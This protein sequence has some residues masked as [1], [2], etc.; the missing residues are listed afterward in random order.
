MTDFIDAQTGEVLPNTEDNIIVAFALYM[1]EASK[2]PHWVK[3]HHLTKPWKASIKERLAES[4]GMPAWKRAI[5]L[6]SESD[7]L[8]GRVIGQKSG[9]RFKMTLKFMLQPVS[10]VSIL[11][12]FYDNRKPEPSR[13]VLPTLSTPAQKPQ[14]AFVPEPLP[15]RLA[16]M[17]VSFRKH[18]YWQKANDAET[19]LAAL[20]NRPAVHV[21]APDWQS[22]P[23]PEKPPV[24][25][26][27]PA[28]FDD[29]PW[30]AIPE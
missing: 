17:I 3:H 25:P 18:G 19:Q 1:H 29:I 7:W 28:V 23:S 30:E 2:Q 14:P 6:A 8:C 22:P 11:D 5:K 24:A 16:A 27:K 9:T 10:F 21:P 4:G 13:L 15:V 12:G 26:R 20:E